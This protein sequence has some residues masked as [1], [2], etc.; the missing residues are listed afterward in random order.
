M[1][2][3]FGILGRDLRRAEVKARRADERSFSTRDSCFAVTLLSL[4]QKITPVLQATISRTINLQNKGENGF[5]VSLLN[6]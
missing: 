2:Y 4:T 5:C 3:F 6:R 1:P